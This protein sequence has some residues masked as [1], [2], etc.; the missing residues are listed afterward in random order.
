M[1]TA[2]T[3]VGITAA[4]IF[5]VAVITALAAMS[6]MTMVVGVDGSQVTIHACI[7]SDPAPNLPRAVH[8][9]LTR[10]TLSPG[11]YWEF[12]R[13]A[14]EIGRLLALHEMNLPPSGA[15]RPAVSPYVPP[16]P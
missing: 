10:P 16:S 1:G 13:A 5:L 2:N 11:G 9:V 3:V 12:P 15:C 14:F 8:L 6:A 4:I 7:P